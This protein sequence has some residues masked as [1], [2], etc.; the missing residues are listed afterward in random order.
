M[1]LTDSYKMDQEFLKKN[2]HTQVLAPLDNI[3]EELRILNPPFPQVL[4]E[5]KVWLNST[6]IQKALSAGL[7]KKEDSGYSLT[8]LSIKV[9][10]KAASIQKELEEEDLVL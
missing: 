6:I 9:F 8:D 5:A 1:P 7:L 10:E 2:P 4:H 3:M